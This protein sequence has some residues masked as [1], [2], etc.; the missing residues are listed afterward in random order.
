MCVYRS[1]KR[2]G[3]VQWDARNRPALGEG[4]DPVNIEDAN[5][6]LGKRVETCLRHRGTESETVREW[7]ERKQPPVSRCC[8]Y[9]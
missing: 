9:C 2:W 5:I 4:K 6:G 3:E 7:C 1:E 8:L